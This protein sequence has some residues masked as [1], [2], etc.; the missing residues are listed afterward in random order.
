MD[1]SGHRALVSKPLNLEEGG[2]VSFW[3]K[4]GPDDGGVQ[5]KWDYEKLRREHM[6]KM[7]RKNE[8]KEQT[9]NMLSPW[10]KGKRLQW[11][12]PW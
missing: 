9:L 10:T 8:E 4:D 7:A 3:L 2:V 5:C 6:E 12:W 11:P 1:S